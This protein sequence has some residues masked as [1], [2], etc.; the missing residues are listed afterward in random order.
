MRQ[1]RRIR[2]NAPTTRVWE[3]VDDDDNIS[4]WM[5][6]V[7]RVTYPDGKPKVKAPGVKFAHELKMQAGQSSYQGEIT[8]YRP[9][10][11]VGMLVEP[12]AFKM[13]VVYHVTGDEDWTLLEYGCDV[14]PANWRGWLIL[15]LSKKQLS[16]II[17]QQLA[18]LKLVAE[19]RIDSV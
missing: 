4:R 11:L 19:G 17:D 1:T 2:I 18:L 16:R 14:R 15:A 7:V 12:Q 13:H 8:E 3:L 10:S 6:Q 5:P 9:G